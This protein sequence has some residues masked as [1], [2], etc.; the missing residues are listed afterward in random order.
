MALQTMDEFNKQ[1][2]ANNPQY[3]GASTSVQNNVAPQNTGTINWDPKALAQQ[4]ADMAKYFPNGLPSMQPQID[5]A[6]QSKLAPSNFK[7]EIPPVISSDATAPMNTT[8]SFTSLQDEINKRLMASLTPNDAQTKAI[9]DLATVR[10]E[11]AKRADYYRRKEEEILGDGSKTKEQAQADLAQL[12]YQKNREMQSLA[13]QENA[14]AQTVQSY[15]G[16]FSNVLDIGRYLQSGA[17]SQATTARAAQDDFMKLVDTFSGSDALQKDIQSYQ[18]TGQIGPGLAP[19]LAQAQSAGYSPM[20]ALSLIQYQTDKVRQAEQKAALDQAKLA[21]SGASTT[22][23][24]NLTAT[25]QSVNAIGAGLL[26][27]GIKAGTLEYAQA[28]AQATAGS[29]TGLS[30]SEV[31]AYQAMANIGS[32]VASL[33]QDITN[34]SKGSDI[35]NILAKYSGK[36]VSSIAKADVALLEAKLASIVA[37]IARTMFGERGVLTDRDI[38]RVM[39]AMPSADAPALMNALYADLVSQV[40]TSAINRLSLDASTGRNVSGVTPY[41]TQ[42]VEDLSSVTPTSG[43]TSSG[44]SYKIIP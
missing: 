32:Q 43:K 35:G 41:I 19:I 24:Q 14:T 33:K 12:S 20:E 5:S 18:T 42:L 44:V 22:K 1:F 23:A 15:Q 17:T 26:S 40:K 36:T 37:P 27:Q 39:S 7:A 21:A 6:T 11:S 34:V 8:S 28:V 31:G 30:A 3:G 13:E 4:Q 10:A 25:I 2:M 16:Q 29:Q 9:D 38:N